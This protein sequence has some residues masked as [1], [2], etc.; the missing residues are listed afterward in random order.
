MLSQIVFM[1]QCLNSWVHASVPVSHSSLFPAAIQTAPPSQRNLDSTSP[2]ESYP[3]PSQRLS[4]LCTCLSK[5][6]QAPPSPCTFNL[7]SLENSPFLFY[8]LCLLASP[9]PQDRNLGWID[10]F[11]LPPA[12]QS[13][14]S[15]PLSHY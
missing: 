1:F 13:S 2:C 10:L 15:K 11:L 8:Y 6:L 4:A 5:P 9:R 7:P 3:K 14:T 12:S